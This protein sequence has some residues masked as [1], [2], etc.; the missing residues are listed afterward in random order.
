MEMFIILNTYHRATMILGKKYNS[1][2]YYSPF[3][4]STWILT[5]NKNC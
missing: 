3:N 2:G 5:G 1:I 4:S